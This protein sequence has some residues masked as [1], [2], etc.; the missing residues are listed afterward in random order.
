MASHDLKI[1]E[2]IS[3]VAD[4]KA[5]ARDLETEKIKPCVSLAEVEK[6]EL[7]ANERGYTI[8]KLRKKNKASFTQLIKENFYHLV[9]GKYLTVAEEAM[10]IRLM[11]LTEL[12]SNALTVLK[13]TKDGYE[14]IPG[15][16][17]KI[18]EIAKM[19]GRDLSGTSK[20]INQLIKKG[21]LYEIVD[22][23]AL[24]NHGRNIEE[25]PIYFNPEIVLAGDRGR[26]NL[27]LCRIHWFND[28]LEKAG[29]KLPWKVWYGPGLDSGCLYRRNT[30]L[31]NKK[32]TDTR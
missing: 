16:T 11:P 22:T 7:N 4:K 26:I 6:Q 1:I 27:T 21:I 5:R 30:W 20:L 29:I 3:A 10:I 13:E 17:P 31:K 19:L 24:K 25:R 12:N 14:L 15:A 2:K 23:E 18:T 8:I 28:R 32:R 9:L